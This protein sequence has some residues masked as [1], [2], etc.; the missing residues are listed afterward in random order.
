MQSLPESI[1]QTQPLEQSVDR[2]SK[3]SELLEQIEK[4]LF[5]EP[6]APDSSLNLQEPK[7]FFFKCDSPVQ[8]RNP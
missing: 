2:V 3:F 7:Y 1:T 4:I 8:L 5:V 6:I